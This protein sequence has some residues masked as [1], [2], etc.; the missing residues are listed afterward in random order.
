MQNPPVR[1]NEMKGI[2]SLSTVFLV[3][4]FCPQL[5]AQITGGMLDP[6]MDPEDE[7]FSY[8]WHP[9]DVIGTLYAPVASEV[10]PEGYVYTG[11]G[12]LMFFVGNPPEPVEKRIKTLYK[13]YLPIVQYQFR[14]QG[15]RYRF[16][17]FGA[18]LGGGLEGLPVNF[19][20]VELENETHEQRTGF[21]SSAYRFSAPIN[22]LGRLGDYRFSQRFDLL[23]DKYLEGLTRSHPEAR[24]PRRR[25]SLEF[26]PDW[27]YGFSNNA[28]VRDGRILYSFPSRPRPHQVSLALGD[29]GLRAVRYFTGEI[30]ANPNPSYTL[31]SHTPM[32]VVMYRVPL[33]AGESRSLVF[34][35]P[36][37]PIPEGTPEA[38]QVNAAGYEAEFEKTVST[39]E[40]LV[41]RE[42][43]L[44][45]PE[46]K[47]QNY[48]LANTVFD[49][50]AID[51][52]GDDYIPNV[53]QFQYHRFYAGC[54]TAH[55]LIGLDYMGL[56]D[57]ARKA[58]LYSL[59][60]QRADGAFVLEGREY[61]LFESF[62]YSLW[63]WGRHYRLT[64]D[65]SF[66]KTVY[67]G[68][69]RAME[70]EIE[71][72]D[73]DPM[74]LMPPVSIGDDAMLAN[75][76]HTGQNLWLLV[77]IRNAVDL[78]EAIGDREDTERFQEEYD[79]YWSAFEKLLTQQTDRSGGYIPPALEKTLEGNNWD[80]QLLLYPEVLFDPFDPRVTATIETSRRT[81]VEGILG[82]VREN[83]L[84]TESWPVDLAEIAEGANK[85]EGYIFDPRRHLHY[86]HTQDNA[87]NHLVRGTPED[88][89]LAVR[90]LY[91]LLL[92]T[93]STHA[94]QEWGAYPW[95][96][97]DH[98]GHNLIPDG[99][100]S[101]KTIELLRNM[102]V[103]EYED[104]LYLFSALSPAWLKP[105]QKIE[106]IEE[107]T[108]FGPVTVKLKVNSDL[109]HWNW[110]VTLSNKFRRV[111]DKI[112][113]RLPWFYESEKVEVDGLE[114]EP[115]NGEVVLAPD[116]R[117]VRVR[118]R[119]KPETPEISYDMAVD[120]YKTEY[121]LRYR[122]FLKTGVVTP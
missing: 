12:E 84:A 99:P 120:N 87:Q 106:V 36:I 38:Q 21:L 119:I 114:V 52:V 113:M 73:S 75:V 70:W 64:G 81:Y 104:N 42:A 45:F 25:H 110:E 3:L 2:L 5:G 47:V 39:W 60:A 61:R 33:E 6:A 35:L 107:P 58:L 41:P 91:A 112:V 121:R 57:I 29:N 122:H 18:D 48:L 88:Q 27:K 102:L 68:V 86:W 1:G 105:G 93:T 53:N 66:L 55:M 10:T 34:K 63:G 95:S 109:A 28:V 72:T 22:K 69:Q 78:A 49:L 92:H 31:D 101:G 56:K 85:G 8:F 20:K 71:M 17:M 9:S 23:P 54:D 97:R 82:Y 15:V 100:A 16:T 98:S 46:E 89:E 24:D 117:E 94:P 118:G 111:P 13:G 80:N 26:N 40:K 83:A 59:I 19:V 96:T 79:R 14:R 103:R 116:T 7:P 74:G 11:F 30:R 44:R 77:G 51:K 4:C 67:P 76:R 43:P 62:G 90:D 32:G 65:E 37:V 108:E 115:Q 50:L